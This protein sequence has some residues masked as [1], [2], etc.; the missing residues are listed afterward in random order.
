[1][2]KYMTMIH[3][4]NIYDNFPHKDYEFDDQGWNGHKAKPLFEKLIKKTK[5]SLIIEVGTWKGQSTMEMGKILRDNNIDCTIICVDT[6]LGSIEHRFSKTSAHNI[7]SYTKHG[8][9]NLYYQ[10]LANVIHSG[11]EKYIVPL[12]ST[13][14]M[15]ADYF[16]TKSVKADLIYIDAAHDAFN[17]FHDVHNYYQLLRNENSIIFGDDAKHPPV[18]EGVN[19]FMKHNDMGDKKL[20][21]DIEQDKWWIDYSES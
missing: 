7:S 2:N 18:I 20:F 9:P 13:S 4:E 11:L 16:Y 17:V 19:Q 3:G 15:G 6:W 1:M 8:W 21:K 10:F 14:L 12:P 5:P